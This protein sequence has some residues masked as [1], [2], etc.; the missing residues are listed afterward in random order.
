MHIS[1]VSLL[2][3]AGFSFLACAIEFTNH[4]NQDSKAELVPE[5]LDSVTTDILFS[6]NSVDLLS[7]TS[8]EDLDP[9]PEPTAAPTTPTASVP[10]TGEFPTLFPYFSFTK[11][12]TKEKS[13]GKDKSKPKSVAAAEYVQESLDPV[14]TDVLSSDNS[15]LLF[16][17]Q[18]SVDLFAHPPKDEPAPSAE[19]TAAPTTPTASVPT[20]GEIPTLFPYFYYTKYPTKSK[21]KGK[22]ESKSDSVEYA[23]LRNRQ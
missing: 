2:V 3:V 17:D 13:K 18:D 11:S 16:L 21:G 8:T 14:T 23:A 10:T 15:R 4:A 12:P 7:T 9:S 22:S 19:P 6:D 5:S 1:S 20:T